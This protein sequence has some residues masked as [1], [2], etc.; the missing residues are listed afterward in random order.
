MI[1]S[2]VKLGRLCRVL[3]AAA[4]TLLFAVTAMGQSSPSTA[5]S[6]L[7]GYASTARLRNDFGGWV[8]MQL[9]VGANPLA[10]SSLG[11]IC[12]AGNT[13]THVVKFVNVSDGSDVSGASV[14]LNMA[15][16]T[17]GQFVYGAVGPIN[18]SAR[19]SYYL[20][21][22][23]FSGGDQWYDQGAVSSTSDATANRAE[24]Y[25]SGTWNPATT[26]YSYVPPNFQ[27]SVNNQS[28]PVTVYNT[29]L[30]ANTSSLAFGSE[31]V[32][33][34]IAL[35][36]TLTNS[37]LANVNI[38]NIII[39][40]PGFNVSGVSVGQILPPG[41]SATLNVTFAP[42]ATGSVTGSVTII[43]TATNPSLV[44]NLSGTG[45]Q[46]V[47]HSVALNWIASTSPVT[48][49]NVFRSTVSGGSYTQLNSSQVPI[50][51]YTDSTVQSGQ[52]YYY[53]VTAVNASG[54][55]S[56][57]SNQTSAAIP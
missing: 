40:G 30:T 47:S 45:T 29:Y 7:T 38:S 55:Q 53:V 11:R 14:S 17:P 41:Q 12:A 4:P 46:I 42:A 19:T 56:T 5:K 20:A 35:P 25:S 28:A 18:L 44:I 8:G 49:Y 51:Q 31:Y 26:G 57:Y 24:Y 2:R 15:G 32:G 39:S 36:V 3:L 43:S 9:T 54:L 34:S 1:P 50:T 16:C 22:Q 33:A 37:G 6:F 27:Y 21:S 13:G 23:E 48:G 52:T 10:V